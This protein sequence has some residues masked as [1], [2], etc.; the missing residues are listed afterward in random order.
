MD[1]NTKRWQFCRRCGA[2]RYMHAFQGKVNNQGRKV[3]WSLPD[4]VVDAIKETT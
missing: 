3:P 4:L 1:Q 2:Y